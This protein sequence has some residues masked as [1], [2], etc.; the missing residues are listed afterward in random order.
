MDLRIQRHWN[1]DNYIRIIFVAP[2]SA[3]DQVLQFHSRVIGNSTDTVFL[4]HHYAVSRYLFFV[5]TSGRVSDVKQRK[6]LEQIG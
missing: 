5:L 6:I 1:I 2:V 4:C 3:F